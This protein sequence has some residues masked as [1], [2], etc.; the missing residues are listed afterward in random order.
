MKSKKLIKKF[1]K[2]A[3]LLNDVAE[4]LGEVRRENTGLQ[5][6]TEAAKSALRILG[7]ELDEA[8]EM[9]NTPH[10][11]RHVEVAKL[12]DDGYT[13]SL[14]RHMSLTDCLGA[15]RASGLS[16]G[17]DS[18]ERYGPTIGAALSALVDSLH[19]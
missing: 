11:V 15:Y 13:V 19:V 6:E 14:V 5:A 3:R 9:L 12:L 8:R 1:R 4:M 2:Q 18:V 16:L 17:G 10:V 7:A